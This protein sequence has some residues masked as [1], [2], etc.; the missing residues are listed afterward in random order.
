MLLVS[1]FMFHVSCIMYMEHE[2]MEAIMKCHVTAKS[3]EILNMSCT[4]LL[5][6][7]ISSNKLFSTDISSTRLYSR[8][9]SSNKLFS[10]DILVVII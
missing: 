1:C 3:I 8:D 6:V 4:R 9:I 5:V 10:T 2:R 7:D